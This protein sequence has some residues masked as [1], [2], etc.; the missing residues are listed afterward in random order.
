[1]TL[2]LRALRLRWRRLVKPRQVTLDGIK[3]FTDPAV[4]PHSVRVAL[5]KETY[6]D[7][8]RQLIREYLEPGDR[9]LE[10]GTGI[11][12]VSLL[13]ASIC[14]PD[15]VLSYEANPLLEPVIRKNYALNGMQPNLRMRAIT[16]DGRPVAFF[17]NDNIISSSTKE[18]EG[19]SEKLEV[20]SDAFDEV[21]RRHRPDVIIMDVEGAE[22]ELLSQSSLQGVRHIIAELH[23]HITGEDQVAKMVESLRAKG[24]TV[25]SQAHRTVLLN[26]GHA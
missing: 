22:I 23:P 8:E 4:L 24:F 19:F 5:F 13:C 9:V 7:Y 10:I 21:I 16:P 18:R 11:G 26:S 20:E 15:N 6:E 3:I 12:F 2:A 17:R 25:R 14:S 1:M